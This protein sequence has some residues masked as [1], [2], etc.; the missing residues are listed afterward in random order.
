MECCIVSLS[1]LNDHRR[2]IKY[3][4]PI[5]RAK[6]NQIQYVPYQISCWPKW[7][8]KIVYKQPEY[9]SG[10]KPIRSSIH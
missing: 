5:Y 4:G 9:G 6:D 3:V 10:C 8:N 7:K 2:H 1:N